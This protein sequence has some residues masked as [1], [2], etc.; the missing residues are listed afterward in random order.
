MR[1]IIAEKAIAGE[2][3][4]SLLAG[5]NIAVKN[6]GGAKLFEFEADG[7]KNVVVPLR[8][9][10]TEVDFPPHMA[11]W[12][13]TDLKRLAQSELLYNVSERGI[14]ELVSRIAKDSEELVIATDA[15]REGESIGFEAVGFARKTNPEIKLRRAYFSA[16]TK[17]DIDSAF[18]SL[19]KPD[20]PLAESADARREIDLIWGAVLTRFL[21]LTSGRMGKEFLSMGRVQGPTLA[22]VVN[23]E[24]ERIAFEQKDY[25]ELEAEFE[26]GKMLFR[27]FHKEGRFWEKQK[28]LSSMPK[29]KT[30]I[31]KGVYSAKKSLRRPVPFN[32]TEFLRAATAIG[33]SAGE[34]M[35]IAESLYQ[36]GFISYPRTDNT[37]YPPNLDLNE[38]LKE[39]L[40]SSELGSLARK[41]LL[42]GKLNPSR[43]KETRDH[44]PIHP[45]GLARREIIGERNWKIYELVARRFLATLSIDALVESTSIELLLGKESF[46]ANGQTILDAGWK[47]FYPYSALTETILPRLSAGDEAQLKKLEL[48][49]KKTMPPA[50][51]SQGSLIKLMED[52]GLGTKSTRHEIIQKLFQRQYV[53]G[54]KAIEPNRISFAVINS[55]EKH[56]PQVVKPDTTA[57]LE[58]RMDVVAAGKMEKSELVKESR[59]L[60][61]GLL[62]KLIANRQEISRE[63]RSALMADSIIGKCAAC[64]IGDLVVRRG[65]TGK[66]FVGC[67]NYPNCTNTYPLPQLGKI[68]ALGKNCGF[69]NAPMVRVSRQRFKFESC[70]NM[71]CTTKDE[72]KKQR[73][74]REAKAANA[75][76]AKP[77]AMKAAVVKKTA[78]KNP[79]EKPAGKKPAPK[80][81]ESAVVEKQI[82]KLP[83]KPAGKTTEKKPRKKAVGK[84]L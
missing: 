58:R 39:L 83:K 68:T 45:V 32:T 33:F 3:I 81:A 70:L 19:S 54:T 62:E 79:A 72:W 37:A 20:Q 7:K 40:A 9:H 53:F 44:P 75:K 21:S 31:V 22:L 43:G 28:A 24:K 27:A 65:K 4:A 64:G 14:A 51:Y 73:A 2:R 80:P 41:I 63:L 34:A 59:E 56:A 1:L 5:K 12:L 76:Q 30:G 67:T 71:D 78:E 8:G 15:D 18:S 16:I 6:S 42:Q 84:I 25:W 61:L 50:R 55:L 38:I 17:K 69:C 74:E 35:S 10:V 26:K 48:L 82:E 52:K 29:E 11:S 36:H 23:R 66:R 49:E 77:A 46:I 47:E 60:L 57:E 13:G